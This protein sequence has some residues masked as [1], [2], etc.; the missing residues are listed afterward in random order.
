MRK[1]SFV[2]MAREYDWIN[3]Q[4]S[5]KPV[6]AVPRGDVMRGKLWG[7]SDLQGPDWPGKDWWVRKGCSCT[8]DGKGHLYMWSRRGSSDV[9]SR[10][11][12]K[13]GLIIQPAGAISVDSEQVTR[14]TANGDVPSYITRLLTSACPRQEKKTFS[15]LKPVINALVPLPTCNQPQICV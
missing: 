12:L 8:E 9:R 15:Q 2:V 3:I 13:T 6:Q 14:V 11:L 1:P 4:Q 10:C 7:G 5:L